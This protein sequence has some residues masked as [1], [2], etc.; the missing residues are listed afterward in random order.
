M[1]RGTSSADAIARTCA[2]RWPNSSLGEKRAEFRI[3]CQPLIPLQPSSNPDGLKVRQQLGQLLG[4][5]WMPREKPLQHNSS[6]CVPGFELQ[7]ARGDGR[8]VHPSPR[9]PL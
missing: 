9:S 1:C 8:S 4:D 6:G 3:R 7:E 2:T 5:F